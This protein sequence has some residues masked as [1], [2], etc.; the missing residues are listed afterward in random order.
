MTSAVLEDLWRHLNNLRC[1]KYDPCT[2]F[3]IGQRFPDSA[4]SDG[5]IARVAQKSTSEMLNLLRLTE[6]ASDLRQM[7]VLKAFT[8]KN[9]LKEVMPWIMSQ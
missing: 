9:P 5:A 6:N 2:L 3:Q 7:R 4:W 1:M 8:S